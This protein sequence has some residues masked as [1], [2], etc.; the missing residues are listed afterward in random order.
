[1]GSCEQ[2][3]A[4]TGRADIAF[5]PALGTRRHY[6]TSAPAGV[7]NSRH[8]SGTTAVIGLHNCIIAGNVADG[9]GDRDMG[10]GVFNGLNDGTFNDDIA[11][12][13]LIHCT[14][15]GNYAGYKYGGAVSESGSEFCRMYFYNSISRDNDSA[16][17]ADTFKNQLYH[18]GNYVD[19]PHDADAFV[20][21]GSL[22]SIYNPGSP[23]TW[24]ASDPV[25]VEAGTTT[26]DW[27]SAS[28][29]DGVTT[30]VMDEDPGSAEV[31]MLFKPYPGDAFMLLIKEVDTGNDLLHCWGVL[32]GSYDPQTPISGA[33]YD[34]HIDDSGSAEDF[35][36]L[37]YVPDDFCDL[38]DDGFT[39]DE[40]PYD[41]DAD[42][43][44]ERVSNSVP[45][46]GCYEI[47]VP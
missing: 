21:A 23:P 42:L 3:K 33:L 14:L 45:D 39:D 19:D 10:G 43:E 31:G 36:A 25:F 20:A 9:A 24:T 41:L 40:L 37:G 15:L 32:Q 30:F 13:E 8:T 6:T 47:Q 12:L 38:D 17:E 22:P 11:T 27:N 7:F 34:L 35:G 44:H 2:A 1:M 26:L 18:V 4:H 46:A 16:S 29:V 28:Y 5:L